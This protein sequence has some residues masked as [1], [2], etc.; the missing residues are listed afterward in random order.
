MLLLLGLTATVIGEAV[1]LSALVWGGGVV[2]L[3]LVLVA[4]AAIS[5]I[6]VQPLLRAFGVHPATKDLSPLVRRLGYSACLAATGASPVVI[7]IMYLIVG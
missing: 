1:A 3:G 2:H 5:M 4:I 7:L 6:L